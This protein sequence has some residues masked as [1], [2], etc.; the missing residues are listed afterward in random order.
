MGSNPGPLH[1]EPRVLVTGQ[2][3]RSHKWSNLKPAEHLSP[4]PWGV[5]GETVFIITFAC[6]SSNLPGIGGGTDWDLVSLLILTDGWRCK[7]SLSLCSIQFNKCKGIHTCSSGSPRPGMGGSKEW[8]VPALQEPHSRTQKGPS[9]TP[10]HVHPDPNPQSLHIPINPTLTSS[11]KGNSLKEL[12][13]ALNKIRRRQWQPTP[14]LLPGK[15]H[16]WRSLVGCS[17]WRR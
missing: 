8:A 14:V 6:C 2:P 13:R 11:S 5:L 15:S 10:L 3:G 9:W 1:W 7:S 4:P 17:P 12:S 16:G